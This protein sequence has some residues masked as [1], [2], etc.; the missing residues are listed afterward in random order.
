[1]PVFIQ[2]GFSFNAQA[3][4]Q[5]TH[6]VYLHDIDTRSTT[7]VTLPNPDGWEVPEDDPELDIPLNKAA[8]ALRKH[9]DTGRIPPDTTGIEIDDAGALLSCRAVPEEDATKT[10][11]YLEL[12][13]FQLPPAAAANP[14]LRSELTEL[15]RF[16]GPVDLVACPG[17][18]GKDRHVF[19]HASHSPV[20]LWYEVQFLARLPPH[21][22]MVLLDRVVLD[23]VTGSQ[24][25][26]FTMRYVA[27]PTLETTRPPFKL[28]WLRQLMQAVDDLN[29]RHGVIHQDIADRNLIIEPD[30][31][32]IAL[33]DF[34][35]ATRVGVVRQGATRDFEYVWKGRDDG[36]PNPWLVHPKHTA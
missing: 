16:T 7:Q 33:L 19:K 10:T 21:P 11:D 28:K 20:G 18:D 17:G 9:L 27:G 25:V 35:S 24:V 29:L 2:L 3:A 31:D 14:L 30:T 23:E 32:S 8:E 12:E 36:T 1:M 15:A 26:G 4:L 6:E 13:E 22:N 5:D 34:N